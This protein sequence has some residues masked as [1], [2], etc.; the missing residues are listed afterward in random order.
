MGHQ[1][2]LDAEVTLALDR[3]VALPGGGLAACESAS[4]WAIEQVPLPPYNVKIILCFK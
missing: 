4:V 3:D 1:A 2:E